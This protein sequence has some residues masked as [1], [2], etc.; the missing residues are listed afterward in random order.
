MTRIHA[1]TC[2]CILGHS[3]MIT[4]IPFK[5][6]CI[7]DTDTLPYAKIHGQCPKHKKGKKEACINDKQMERETLRL[8]AC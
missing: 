3:E 7:V 4:W 6:E 5:N 1:I 2:L 8:R